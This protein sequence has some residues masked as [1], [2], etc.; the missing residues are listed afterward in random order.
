M[1]TVFSVT[2]QHAL[3]TLQG[4]IA[5]HS[6]LS[7]FPSG[8]NQS[9]TV[10]VFAPV[11]GALVPIVDMIFHSSNPPPPQPALSPGAQT[12]PCSTDLDCS[13]QRQSLGPS[14]LGIPHATPESEMGN[15]LER[16]LLPQLAVRRVWCGI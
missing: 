11:D 10:S 4:S 2:H 1:A 6:H 12:Q 9:D 5:C 14:E 13:R 3:S 16:V 7:V 15:H 8:S